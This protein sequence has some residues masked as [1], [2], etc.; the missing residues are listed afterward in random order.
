MNESSRAEVDMTIVNLLVPGHSEPTRGPWRA[1]Y[2]GGASECIRSVSLWFMSNVPHLLG[3]LLASPGMQRR[4]TLLATSCIF[5]NPRAVAE[6]GRWPSAQ[7]AMNSYENDD[8]SYALHMLAH[9]DAARVADQVTRE[10]LAAVG[11]NWH[12]IAPSKEGVEDSA[13]D[14]TLLLELVLLSASVRGKRPT[15]SDRMMPQHCRDIF[16]RLLARQRRDSARARS[17]R[18]REQ[19]DLSAEQLELQRRAENQCAVP[20]H[21]GIDHAGRET[22]VCALP[23][24]TPPQRAPTTLRAAQLHGDLTLPASA[25]VYENLYSILIDKYEPLLPSGPAAEDA[26]QRDSFDLRFLCED[27][28]R[29]HPDLLQA[30]QSTDGGKARRKDSYLW[31]HAEIVSAI[32]HHN[33]AVYEQLGEEGT[34]AGDAFLYERVPRDSRAPSSIKQAREFR[35]IQ[36]GTVTSHGCYRGWRAR[37]SAPAGS[38]RDDASYNSYAVTESLSVDKDA[39]KAPARPPAAGAAAAAAAGASSASAD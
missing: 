6:Y 3:H 30:F 5:V 12:L 21:L 25:N 28:R 34:G 4:A 19:S 36:G 35:L 33:G 18:A 24:G 26:D 11:I 23:E 14:A 2:E 31:L 7:E 27:L 20:K 1:L 37:R 8:Q 10:R 9:A 29:H 32:D 22:I 38:T 15:K 16:D 17:K 13:N 39:A